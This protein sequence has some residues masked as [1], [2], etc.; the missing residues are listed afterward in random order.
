MTR[1][2]TNAAPLADEGGG[3][4]GTDAG[5]QALAPLPLRRTSA[6]MSRFHARPMGALQFRT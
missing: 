5:A 4:C 6:S 2:D 3:V 1:D